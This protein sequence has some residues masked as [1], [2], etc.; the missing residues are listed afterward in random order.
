MKR[1]FKD[2]EPAP[3]YFLNDSF[4]RDEVLRQ[5]D[6]MKENGIPAYFLHVRD[7]VTDQAWGTD[8]FFSNVRFIAE[9]SIKRGITMWLY[10][11]DSYPS[12]QCG[13]MVVIDHPELEGRAL[14]FTKLEVKAGET[15]RRQ[16][17]R[18][19]GVAAY[20]V[21]HIG[22]EEKAVKLS[23]PFGPVRGH[24]YR[25]DWPST[26]YCDMMEDGMTYNHV[27]A[28]TAFPE[29]MFES[30]IKEDCELYIVCSVPCQ[31]S[32]YSTNLDC[33][34]KGSFEEYRKRILERY[35][36]AVGDLF[37]D[38]IP[39]IFI[40]EPT[41]GGDYSDEL[42]EFFFE[43]YGYRLEDNLYK[44]CSEYTGDSRELRRHYSEARVAMFNE[45]FILPIKKW[46]NE[47]K[48]LMTGHF[49]SEENPYGQA[50]AGQS[51]YRQTAIM[52]IP[53]FD[54]ITTNVGD[55]DHC[56]LV[57][58]AGIVASACAQEGKRRILAES[59]A[60][61]PFNMNYHGLRKTADWL[62]ACGINW[63]VPHGFHYG[64]SA[65]HRADAG[66]SFFFQDPYFE[67]YKRFAE[68]A[69][70]IC[71]LLDDY[72]R[73][74]DI[75]LIYPE[76][77]FSENCAMRCVNIAPTANEKV[78][79]Y[80]ASM[81]EAVRTFMKAHVGWDVAD[82][83][84]AFEGNVV[85]GKLVIGNMSYSKVIVVEAGDGEREAYERL[86]DAGVD[87]ILYNRDTDLGDLGGVTMSGD[88]ERV[89]VYR[90]VNSNGELFFL[91]N[92]SKSYARFSM[93]VGDK[94]AWVYDAEND[95]SRKICANEGMAELALQSYGAMAI[96]ISETPVSDVGDDYAPEDED[97]CLPEYVISPEFTYMPKGARS[98]ISYFD[99]K[100]EKNGEIRE[101][102]EVRRGALREYIG[103]HDTI[104]FPKFYYRPG[105]D[106]GKRLY[107]TYPCNP[108]YTVKLDCCGKDDYL[109]FD[110]HS[111]EGNFK[112]F[113]NGEEITR[114]RFERVRVYDMSNFAI[115][116]LWRDGENVLEIKI[117]GA[118]E[119]D[120]ANG[121]IYI[122]KNE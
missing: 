71:K 80:N 75:L 51:V 99:L 115:R 66:K 64:Y 93:R 24:W 97:A 73:Q 122:M 21:T 83:R 5:L 96:V 39:G 12:G 31:S 40:D 13:G 43:R 89:Q 68:Y 106:I 20:T 77:G 58:G 60:L 82:L 103:T 22:G 72:D 38:K 59:F 95:V 119:F 62:F 84:A 15:V 117:V 28:L 14:Q 65:Y 25:M 7:G 87:C 55:I 9:E 102:G 27:R 114:D 35:K 3:F 1:I 17:G 79:E 4:D 110:K 49:N 111:V 109:L 121:D 67:D 45:N 8:I 56:A 34:R 105:F 108:I 112:I 18:A 2:Y 88:S 19:R 53:G 104:F 30:E 76:S 54:V 36:D 16:L 11:E 26:Y 29:V 78:K 86:S 23:N 6:F 91:Y 44:L 85:D 42:C 52:D 120:G 57:L 69:G 63:I 41:L 70:R 100:I 50:A 98:A 113:W 92:N 47:N 90:K 46:C 74:N 101:L 94:N 81:R 61:S 116:P 10:D 37:G 32:K 107:N 118:N 33:T 48:L